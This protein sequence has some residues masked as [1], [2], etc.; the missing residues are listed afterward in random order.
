MTIFDFAKYKK[1]RRKITMVT[2]YDAAYAKIAALS[3]VDCLLVGDSLSMVI[4]GHE[5]TLSASLEMMARH[6][7]A[8]R[9]G[10]PKTFVIADMP[11][12][13]FRKGPYA[14]VA[15]AGTL[16]RAG[17]DAVKLEGLSGHEDVVAHLV[18]SGIPVA[19]HLGLTPQYFYTLGG[20]KVQGKG[21]EAGESLKA[22]ARR[23][24]EL[25]CFTLVLECVPAV[26]AAEISGMS[27]IPI[28]GIGAG[29]DTDG[30]VLVLYDILGLESGLKPR[31]V[32]RYL[33]GGAL[34][35]EAL[36]RFSADVRSGK[37]PR[38]EESYRP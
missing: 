19:G 12:L 31:F 11:F 9:R 29:G 3:E 4:Y 20:Y 26:L 18:G 35:R 30:Q 10:A 27:T 22:A 15:A 1:D 32:R 25:G 16:M 6:T 13:S 34:S 5:T 14:A 38:E 36:D 21:T 28:I 8:V 23:L 2:C 33:E 7:E 24:E 37:Y 17:A